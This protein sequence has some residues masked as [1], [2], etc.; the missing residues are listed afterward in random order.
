MPRLRINKGTP[1]GQAWLSLDSDRQLVY[2]QAVI[3]GLN[4]GLRHCAEEVAFTLATSI[5]R[6][7][8]PDNKLCVEG[9]IQQLRTWSKAGVSKF[10]YS[11]PAEEYA[12]SLVKFYQAYPDYLDLSPSY[13]LIYMDDQHG[14]SP[15][16]IFRLHKHSFYG[17]KH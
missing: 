10:K 16:E 8:S 3:E 5:S 6:D 4:Q 9:L 2:V 11:K 17:F 15:E 7:L 12:Q 13:L 14:M 1:S